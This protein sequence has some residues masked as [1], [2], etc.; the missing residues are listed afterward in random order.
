MASSD[1]VS[2]NPAR[3]VTKIVM[4]RAGPV[5]W[6]IPNRA[7]IIEAR[8]TITVAAEAVMTALILLTVTR[9]ASSWSCRPSSSRKRDIKKIV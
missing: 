8:P 4:A 3:S 5:V 6:I 9:K 2:V 1:G 7:T